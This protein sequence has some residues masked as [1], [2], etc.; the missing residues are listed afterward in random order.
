[1]TFDLIYYLGR[2]IRS[3]TVCVCVGVSTVQKKKTTG[4]IDTKFGARV[5]YRRSSACVDP[6]VKRLKVKV[7]G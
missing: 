6:E 7:T 2:Q 1:M 4:V 5:L 3:V